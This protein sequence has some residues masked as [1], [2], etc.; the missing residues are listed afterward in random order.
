MAAISLLPTGIELCH[1]PVQDGGYQ[2]PI[3]REMAA[4]KEP[5]FFI[6][7]IHLSFSLHYKQLFLFVFNCEI[8]NNNVKIICFCVGDEPEETTPQC[9][10]FMNIITRLKETFIQGQYMNSLLLGCRYFLY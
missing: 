2:S 7:A 8:P 6:K 9:S 10:C 1:L 3:V 4:T 5:R